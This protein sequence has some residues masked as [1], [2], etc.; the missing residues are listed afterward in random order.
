[1]NERDGGTLYNT[2]AWFSSNGELVAKHRKL[3]PTGIERTVWGRG[4][5]R[6]VFV[7][8]AGFAKLGGLVCFEHSIDLSRYPQA[9]LGEQIHV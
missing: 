7:I 8:D 6:D 4:D 9:A 5:G 1:M 2:Q 3:Q